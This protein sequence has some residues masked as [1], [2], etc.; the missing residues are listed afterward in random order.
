MKIGRKGNFLKYRKLESSQLIREQKSINKNE[1]G[2]V[3]GWGR[4]KQECW[5]KNATEE[6]MGNV[7]EK[8]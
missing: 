7:S 4:V 2:H 3:G 6:G 5:G 1:F 8:E